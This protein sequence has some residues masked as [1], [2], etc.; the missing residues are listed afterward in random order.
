MVHRNA[1]KYWSLEDKP[2]FPYQ[3]GKCPHGGQG[4]GHC[5]QTDEEIYGEW[6]RH[7]GT[8]L[9]IALSLPHFH[10]HC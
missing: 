2:Y 4:G 3:A 10:C 6:L 1:E 5:V 7:V 9:C 8:C